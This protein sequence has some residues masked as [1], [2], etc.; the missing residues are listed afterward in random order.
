[1]TNWG[2][3]EWFG[4]DIRKMTAKERSDAVEASRGKED[5][6]ICPFAAELSPDMKCFKQSGVCSIR[7]YI[8]TDSGKHVK[9]AESQPTAVCPNRFLQRDAGDETVFGFIARE[10]FDTVDDVK[11]I[12]EIPFLDKVTATG[13]KRPAKAGRIDWIVVPGP[14]AHGKVTKI[15]WIAVE[16]Q[17]VY[18]SGANIGGDIS[19][20]ALNPAKLHPPTGNRRPDFRSSG[21]KRLAPQLQVKS[22]VMRRWGK[23]VAVVVDEAFFSELAPLTN[24]VTDFDNAEIVWI[25]MK[26]TTGMNLEVSKVVFAELDDS[27]AALQATKPMSRTKFEE[28]LRE[29][30]GKDSSKVFNA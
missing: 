7:E 4:N 27:I 11:V 17:A 24:S 30:L 25:V 2:I 26:Y 20:Y 19:E 16:T 6:P 14:P 12:K 9:F 15:E 22:P 28:G 1:M 3:A 8:T 29:H 5:R 21:A 23:K 10:L 18:F 13:A